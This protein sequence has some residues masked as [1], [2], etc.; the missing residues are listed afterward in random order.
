[1]GISMTKK[2][3]A[4]IAGYSYRQLYN[5]DRDL[6]DNGKL[7]VEGEGGKYDLAVFVQRWVE[8]NANREKAEAGSLDDAKR[9]HEIIKMRKTELEVAKMEGSLVDVDDVR[10]LWG[11]IAANVMQKMILLPSKIAPQVIDMSSIQTIQ[12]I[13]DKEIR[14][15]LNE[16]ADTPL[17]ESEAA[18]EGADEPE[19]E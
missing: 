9:E 3:L 6:P 13:I 19:E 11:G 8:Y 16:I 17:P 2:E 4:S 5:I 10:R 18:S 15:V 12:A 1:M 14:E 7:F